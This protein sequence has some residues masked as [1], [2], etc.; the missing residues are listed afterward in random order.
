MAI[1]DAPVVS[2]I[3]AVGQN[4][5]IG[6]DND[7][8]WHIPEDLRRF[9]ALTD[10]QTLVMGRKTYD[11]IIARLSRPLPGRPHWVLTR[12]ADWRPSADHTDQVTRFE[13]MD[14]VMTH[15]RRLGMPSLWVIGGAELYAQALDYAQIL[16]LTEVGLQVDGDA[17]F[18]TWGTDVF[19]KQFKTKSQTD[20]EISSKGPRYR[21]CQFKRKSPKIAVGAVI[22]AAGQG[23]RMGNRPKSLI[24][25]GGRPL[26]ISLIDTLST[27]GV[28]HITVVLGHYADEIAAQL[29]DTKVVTC[30]NAHPEDGQASSQKLGLSHLPPGLEGIMVVLAD[31]P[32]LTKNDLRD[33]ICRYKKRA[34]GIDMVFPSVQGVP[35]NPVMLSPQ[36]AT[37]LSRAEPALEGRLWRKQNPERC[38]AFETDNQHYVDDLDTPEDLRRLQRTALTDGTNA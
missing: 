4:G 2:I 6:K 18:P 9:K 33:L 5:C 29:T 20:W 15:A 31:Q 28:D 21:F 8:P 10:G 25:V 16:E 30:R 23:S 3:A 17:F 11:S 37:L 34:E 27:V 38:H 12:Q 7:L 24:S 32:S 36:L 19:R 26:I 13:S 22:L 14:E 1:T 35:G